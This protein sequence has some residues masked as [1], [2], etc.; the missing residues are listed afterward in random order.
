MKKLCAIL[1]SISFS[2]L[3]GPAEEKAIKNLQEAEGTLR[4]LCSPGLQELPS[5]IARLVGTENPALVV[6]I[7]NAPVEQIEK[8][9]D[10]GKADLAL[11]DE[12]ICAPLVGLS[13]KPFAMKG[14]VL[15]VNDGV[16]LDSINARQAKLILAGSL[17]DW[18]ALSM[19]DGPLRVYLGPE[20][21]PKEFEPV[22]TNS[23]DLSRASKTKVRKKDAEEEEDPDHPKKHNANPYLRKFLPVE[24]EAKAMSLVAQDPCGV[25]PVKM[26]SKAPKGVKFLKIDGVAPEDEACA[27]G[28]YPLAKRVSLGLP[29]K[30]SPQAKDFATLLLSVELE[31]KLR[32]LG[33]IPLARPTR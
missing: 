3:G 9:M 29:A 28:R 1:L 13:V 21:L 17:N 6:R 25:A 10:G 33:L 11:V 31:P 23:K 32:E 22:G 24:S 4:I 8:E 20:R 16:K 5:G 15:A 30:A 26:T 7:E 12:T 18:C 27:A 2:C 14:I 19:P